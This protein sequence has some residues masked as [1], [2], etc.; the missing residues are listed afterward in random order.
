MKKLRKKREKADKEELQRIMED[1]DLTW[2]Q[3]K[4]MEREQ[5]DKKRSR[6]MDIE[7]E[8]KVTQRKH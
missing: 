4:D 7:E 3:R 1:M 6:T 8:V 5:A 2:E